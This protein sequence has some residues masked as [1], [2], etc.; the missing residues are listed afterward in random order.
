M[1][2]KLF[3][4][5]FL[6]T[7]FLLSSCNNASSTSKVDEDNIEEP[8]DQVIHVENISLNKTSITLK[9]GE[10]D[11]LIAVISPDNATNKEV[12]WSSSNSS[13][14]SVDNGTITAKKEGEVDIIA[15]SV[16][17]NK[18]AKAHVLVIEDAP[19]NPEE[20]PVDPEEPPVD[21]ED[22]ETPPVDPEEPP[23]D[24][25]EPPVDPGTDPEDPPV[26]PEEPPVDPEEPPVDPEEET[27]DSKIESI[28]LD[29]RELDLKVN[30]TYSL[31]VNFVPSDIDLEYKDVNWSVDDETIATVSKYGV[32]K[33]V[34]EG[35]TVVH[36]VTV[37]GNRHASC[38]VNVFST[39]EQIK[40][41]Y[42]KVA[43]MDSI[44]AGDIIVFACPQEGLT[45]SFNRK[46]GYLFPVQTSFS[47]DKNSITSL[48]TDTAEYIVGDSSSGL[49]LENQNG[50]FL[51]AKGLKNIN[52]IA[53]YKG[54]I[55]WAFEYIDDQ[56]GVSVGNYVYSTYDTIEGWLM[57]NTKA[58]RFTLYD[59]SEQ[60]D[61]FLPTIYRLERI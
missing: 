47:S 16:D 3:I 44:K 35:T 11:T 30:K 19:V 52:H 60:I 45:A 5:P 17:G 51:A 39:D 6:L 38:R 40:R 9:I 41:E 50:M 48:G 59:S 32:V 28:S 14:V 29:K 33:A 42:R 43:D 46:D 10:T 8:I 54:A 12:K 26:D 25:E 56:V 18:T 1:K 20:P 22:P 4:L 37:E 7:A 23:I 21:P 58:N 61:M 36:C 49:T 57:F 2:K 24:P 31:I 27:D 13:V 53:S 34:K 55:E 15:K